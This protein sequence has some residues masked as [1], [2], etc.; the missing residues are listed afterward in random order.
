MPESENQRE[1]MSQKIWGSLPCR[2]TSQAYIQGPS[3]CTCLAY[4]L[5]QCACEQF[6]VDSD[7]YQKALLSHLIDLEPVIKLADY[8]LIIYMI[9]YKAVENKHE[10]Y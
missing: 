7:S 5:W 8:E 3:G 1:T 2:K 6:D 9:T 4:H 10:G